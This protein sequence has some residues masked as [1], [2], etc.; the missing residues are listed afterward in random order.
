ME[1]VCDNEAILNIASNP[2]FH[3]RTKHIEIECY[4]VR[5]TVFSGSIF[6]RFVRSSDQSVDIFTK[7]L[8]GP[9]TSYTCNRLS[10]YN[11]YTLACR[12][13]GC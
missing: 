1:L 4:F 10:T 9:R 8:A 5:E 2:I 12:G 6:T 11:L 13:V 3:E 7:S